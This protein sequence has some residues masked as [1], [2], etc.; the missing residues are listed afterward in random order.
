MRAKFFPLKFIALG[1]DQIT[2]SLP[3]PALLLLA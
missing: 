3:Y 1:I 2:D